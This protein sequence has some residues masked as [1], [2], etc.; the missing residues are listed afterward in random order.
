[1]LALA[2]KGSNLKTEQEKKYKSFWQQSFTSNI[3]IFL[4]YF[5]L[6]AVRKQIDLFNKMRHC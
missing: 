1:M 3:L 4:L 6:W 5:T 2:L